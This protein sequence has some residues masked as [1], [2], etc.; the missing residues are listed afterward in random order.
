MATAILGLQWG[1]EGK[2]K[3]THLLARDADMV[4]RF[5]GGP[6]AGHTVI[7]RGVKFGTHLIPAGA[8]YPGVTSVLAAGMVIDVDLLAREIAAVRDHIGAAPRV[9]LA[10]NAHLILPYHRTLEELEGSGAR[11]GTTRRGIAPAYRDKVAHVGVRAGDLLEPEVLRQRIEWRLDLL[12]REWPESEEMQTYRAD[13]LTEGLLA[14][15]EGLRGGIGDVS[16]VVADALEQGR[17]V[18]F[19]GAQGTLLDVDFGTYPFVTSSSTTY[20]GIGPSLGMALPSIERRVGVAKAYLT[21][22]GEGP[23]PTELDDPLGAG[24]RERGGEYGTTTGRPRRCGWLDLVALRYAVRLNA[25]TEIALTKLDVLDGLE[26]IRLGTEYRIDGRTVDR[27][28]LSGEV[29]ARCTPVYETVPGW[30]GP[31]GQP[32][33]LDALPKA[34]AEYVRRIE[35]GVGVPVTVVSYGPRPEETIGTTL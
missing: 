11:F 20:A 34:A 33:S 1:D 3:I 13:A 35:R 9:L 7:D 27:Y 19:E 4:V 25:V 5:N 16:A 30:R 24:L 23:F 6:N 14:A 8:F 31:L 32:A 28:P 12:R 29:L 21:R 15:A 10:E 2:G 18:L 26:E 17:S 22:V